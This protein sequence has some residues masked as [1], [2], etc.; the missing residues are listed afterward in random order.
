MHTASL[1]QSDRQRSGYVRSL[2]P[3]RPGG[4]ETCQQKQA[5]CAAV[6][7][8]SSEK[9]LLHATSV[10]NHGRATDQPLSI[11]VS[12]RTDFLADGTYLCYV[13]YATASQQYDTLVLPHLIF[14]FSTKIGQDH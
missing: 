7:L 10:E 2:C 4:E 1:Q 13:Y 14:H 9:I 8:A 5:A 12:Q 11:T 3:V 6:F